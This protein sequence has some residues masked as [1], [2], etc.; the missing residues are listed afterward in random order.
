MRQWH[1]WIGFPTAIVFIFIA[2]TGIALQ[3]DLVLSGK[4]PPG[5]HASKGTETSTLPET[6]E[7]QQMVAR[8][9]DTAHTQAPELKVQRIELSFKDGGA[10]ATIGAGDPFGPQ[11]LIDAHTGAVIPVPER[12]TDWHLLL[13]DLHAGYSFGT[14]GRIISVLMGI[15]L[16]VM[17][18]T[19]FKVYYDLWVRR[20]RS[21]RRNPFWR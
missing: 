19:G 13:Q 14:V 3:L 11:L 5:Q 21:G 2:I 18:G 1:R 8:V 10:Q 20:W 16:L 15:A 6:P 4:S 7:L 12:G 17:C 9:V